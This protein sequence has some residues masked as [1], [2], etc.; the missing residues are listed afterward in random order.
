MRR[1]RDRF[2]EI[3]AAG[4]LTDVNRRNCE[5]RTKIDHF[6]GSRLRSDPLDGYERVAVISRDDDSARDLA[7]RREQRDFLASSEVD[8]RYRLAALVRSDKQFAIMRRGEVVYAGAHREPS[9]HGPAR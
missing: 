1:R 3:D 6:D 2:P 7:P 9:C 5:Q 4:L 8:D